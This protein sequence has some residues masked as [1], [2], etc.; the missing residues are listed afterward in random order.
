MTITTQRYRSTATTD[1]VQ[2]TGGNDQA[3]EL[4]AWLYEQGIQAMYL[5]GTSGT[6]SE[7]MPARPERLRVGQIVPGQVGKSNVIELERGD[8]LLVNNHVVAK[9]SGVTFGSQWELVDASPQPVI[10]GAQA[11]LDAAATNG[12]TADEDIQKTEYPTGDDGD[13][14]GTSTIEDH[15]IDGVNEP[16]PGPATPFPAPWSDPPFSKPEP[17]ST[18]FTDNTEQEGS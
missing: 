4:I 6:G 13:L 1:A 8:W 3:K 17:V 16:D 10:I 15:V 12:P 18:V 5:P 2:F 7:A 14:T 11:L 9:G